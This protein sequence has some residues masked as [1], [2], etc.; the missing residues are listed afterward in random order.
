MQRGPLLGM[1]SVEGGTKDE[2]WFGRGLVRLSQRASADKVLF[3]LC[4]GDCEM[5]LEAEEKL[6]VSRKQIVAGEKS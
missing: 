6:L 2:D 4:R 3:Q 5:Y 1:E